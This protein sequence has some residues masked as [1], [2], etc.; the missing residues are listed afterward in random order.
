ME[1]F[2]RCINRIARCSNLYRSEKLAGDGLNGCQSTYVLNICR[3]PGISQEKLAR[4]ILINKSNVARQLAI[5]EQN[6][7]VT[8]VPSESD[9]R[10]LCIY[11]TEKMKAALPKV[12]KVLV[13][14]REYLTEDFTPE[15]K[16]TLSR[17]L[18]RVMD[19]ASRYAKDQISGQGGEKGEG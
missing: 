4:L 17:L 7:F 8:R 16:D 5:L 18:E 9:R 13:D 2:M 14:W 1:T 6:G 11:P 19:R 10:V 12:E 15:E 3:N